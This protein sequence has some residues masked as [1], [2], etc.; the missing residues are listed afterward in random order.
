MVGKETAGL[1]R[2]QVTQR[3][4]GFPERVWEGGSLLR[5]SLFLRGSM[6][7]L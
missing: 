5:G 3:R 7:G 4:H 2:G 1:E 6:S